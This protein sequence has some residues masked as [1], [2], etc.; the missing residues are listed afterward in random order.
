[1]KKTLAAMAM[2]LAALAAAP[3]A[4][5]TCGGVYTVK[6]GDS[7]SAI[8]DK[9]Y[10]KVSMWTAI[11]SANLQT[12][13]PKPNLLQVGMKLSLACIDGLPK[14][15]PGGTEITDVVH[16]SANLVEIAP[17]DAAVSRKINLITGTD[18]APFTHQDLHNGGML[19]DVVNAAFTE[20]APD[21]GY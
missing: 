6:R 9:T 15:L 1:M 5:E 3:A 17:G 8:A 13:G 10:K 11:H 16:T 2:G 21:E 20:A 18:Y 12:I 4:A 19:T 7:L 14:G